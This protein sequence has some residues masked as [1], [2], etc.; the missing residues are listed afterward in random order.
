[1]SRIEEI[2][3]RL[4]GAGSGMLPP[5]ILSR[6][7]VGVPSQCWVWGGPVNKDSGYGRVPYDGRT[8]IVHRVVYTLLVGEIPPGLA[9]DHLCHN[10]DKDCV[11][12]PACLHR[13]CVNPKHLEAVPHRVNLGRGRSRN[14]IPGVDFTALS[15]LKPWRAQIGVNYRKLHLGLFATE[16]E[17]IAARQ[18]A[19]LRYSTPAKP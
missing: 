12:G 2:E 13:R 6:L 7:V 16:A 8:R 9:L 3:Q 10:R 11:G 17:A 15:Q 14:G 19:E 18:A 4:A 5:V 1:M